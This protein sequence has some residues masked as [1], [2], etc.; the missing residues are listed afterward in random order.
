[1]RVPVHVTVVFGAAGLGDT[2]IAIDTEAAPNVA[3][4]V[5]PMRSRV[6]A[7]AVQGRSRRNLLRATT[8]LYVGSDG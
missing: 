7:T 3:G 8:I 1:V 5:A 2:E 4:A 6:S